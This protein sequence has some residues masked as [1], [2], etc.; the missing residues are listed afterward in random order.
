MQ[1]GLWASSSRF[2]KKIYL[3][4]RETPHN[5]R[6]ERTFIIF[7][8]TLLLV[9][10]RC[11]SPVLCFRFW[12]AAGAIPCVP[13]TIRTHLVSSFLLFYFLYYSTIY[14]HI[15]LWNILEFCSAAFSCIFIFIG[16][17]LFF[18]V[19]M[20]V[21]NNKYLPVSIPSG[22]WSGWS[23]FPFQIFLLTIEIPGV[24]GLVTSKRDISHGS[25][26]SRTESHVSY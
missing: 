11:V 1:Q 2:K 13:Q 16:Y 12:S 5:T 8:A 3:A 10:C 26:S 17:D 18:M 19:G 14:H 6:H 25:T 23:V 9:L 22:V 20:L 15:M 4:H 21:I 7:Y 24:W